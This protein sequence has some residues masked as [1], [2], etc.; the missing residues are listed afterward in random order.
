MSSKY[1]VNQEIKAGVM[2]SMPIIGEINDVK[3]RDKVLDALA[4]TLEENEF[5]RMEEIPGLPV[6][7]EYCNQPKHITAVT[8]MVLGMVDCMN[9]ALEEPLEL[10]R[11]LLLACAICHDL[12]NPYEYNIRKRKIWK[13]HPSK[14]GYPCL[15]HTFYGAHIALTVGLPEAVAHACACHS[16][17]GQFV[18]RSL[19]TTI[20]YHV[21]D[22]FWKILR[23]A[24]EIS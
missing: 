2:A 9:E 15:R 4:L 18:E 19:G 21:D 23:S 8:K 12:G 11:D 17:E 6:L 13:E 22:A 10:D 14:E 20:L 24:Y 16:P 3:L 1:E 5:K 7:G